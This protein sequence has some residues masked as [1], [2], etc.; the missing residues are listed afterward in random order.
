MRDRRIVGG[1][2]GFKAR[3]SFSRRRTSSDSRARSDS[4]GDKKVAGEKIGEQMSERWRA[5]QLAGRSFYNR[6]VG[7]AIQHRWSVLAGSCVFLL[8]GGFAASH[9]SQDGRQN[10]E[11]GWLNPHS[12]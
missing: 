2:H 4:H 12:P 3:N 10:T 11:R 7:R 5:T 1:N 9:M 6:L 8:I